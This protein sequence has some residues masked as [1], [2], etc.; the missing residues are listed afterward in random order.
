MNTPEKIDITLP[1]CMLFQEYKPASFG[2]RLPIFNSV[3]VA[4]RVA[5]ELGLTHLNIGQFNSFAKLLKMLEGHQLA[6]IISFNE[7]ETDTKLPQFRHHLPTPS[8]LLALKELA[9]FESKT[10]QN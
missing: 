1:V 6:P 8:F 5:V 3:E 7:E 4:E 9:D 10:E 2:G